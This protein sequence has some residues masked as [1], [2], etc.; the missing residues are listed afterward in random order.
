MKDIII[1]VL[2]KMRKNFSSQKKNIHT[3]EKKG[4]DTLRTY[5]S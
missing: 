2:A 5:Y 3:S 1:I 4:K